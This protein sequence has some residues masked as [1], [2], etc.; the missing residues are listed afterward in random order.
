MRL[1]SFSRFER[2][3]TLLLAVFVDG[4]ASKDAAFDWGE[5]ALRAIDDW[6]AK[7][8]GGAVP[9]SFEWSEDRRKGRAVL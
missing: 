1:S 3:L 6:E 7:G 2:P 8:A 4:P 9:Y 5:A